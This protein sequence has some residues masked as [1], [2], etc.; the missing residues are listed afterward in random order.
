MT[1]HYKAQLYITI[2][3]LQDTTKPYLASLHITILD[4]AR[5]LIRCVV[6][7]YEDAPEY[8]PVRAFV[9]VFQQN[10][11]VATFTSIKA[12]MQSPDLQKQTLRKRK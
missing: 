10:D 5:E 7:K 4:I 8:S 12:A 2:P 3:A 6:V 1:A 9:K 11:S